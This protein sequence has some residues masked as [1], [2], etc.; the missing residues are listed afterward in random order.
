MAPSSGFPSTSC[1]R[2]RHRH[3]VKTAR[4]AGVDPISVRSPTVRVGG[5]V[6]DPTPH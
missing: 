4:S 5:A 1:S 6:A 2:P 3:I